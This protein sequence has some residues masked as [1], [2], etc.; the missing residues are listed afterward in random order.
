M[1]EPFKTCSCCA[2][3]WRDRKSFLEDP[4]LT[5]NGYQAD[6]ELLEE[7]LFYF[8]H[9]RTGCGSTL[10]IPAGQF[11]DLYTGPRYLEQHAFSEE[12]PRYC[13]DKDQLGRCHVLCEC[14]MVREVIQLIRAPRAGGA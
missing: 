9:V 11:L 7:G 1:M 4:S 6:L 10:V 2:H 13:M 8:T 3:E 12:C 14:A 5:L